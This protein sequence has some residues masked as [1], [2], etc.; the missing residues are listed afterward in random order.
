M[1]KTIVEPMTLNIKVPAFPGGQWPLNPTLITSENVVVLVDVGMPGSDKLIVT[2]LEKRG[3]SLDQL[4]T[5]ILTHQ[6]IDHVGSLAKLLEANPNIEVFSHELDRP[7]IEG[8]LPLIKMLPSPLDVQ[9]NEGYVVPTTPV[10]KRTLADG[11]ELDIADGLI[12]IHTPGHTEGHVSL[13]HPAS[14]TLMTGDAMVLRGPNLEGPNPMHTPDLDKAYESLTKFA[15]FDIE[16]VI[17]YHGGMYES[18]TL[19]EEIAQIAATG[20]AK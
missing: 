12:V 20:P 15:A 5:I 11:E 7:Y 1:N 13:Y 4:T 8:D 2:E 9:F 6:D 16:R 10:I 3:L 19:N 18:E 14:K 17:C